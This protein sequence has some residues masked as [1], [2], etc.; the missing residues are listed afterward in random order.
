MLAIRKIKNRRNGACKVSEKLAIMGVSSTTFIPIRLGEIIPHF[1]NNNPQFTEQDF[2]KATT[3]TIETKLSKKQMKRFLTVIKPKKQRLPRK[4]KKR[5]KLNVYGKAKGHGVS[6]TVA[7]E[8]FL[9]YYANNQ[10][11]HH[12]RP[13]KYKYL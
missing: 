5:I 9:V 4:L 1:V 2:K 6:Y 8:N 12:N 3:F 11:H 10:K 13:R 7:G